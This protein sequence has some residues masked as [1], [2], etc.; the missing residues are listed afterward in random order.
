M[1]Q[2]SAAAEGRERERE[3][4]KLEAEAAGG[5]KDHSLREG[6]VNLAANCRAA[7]CQANHPHWGGAGECRGVNRSAGPLPACT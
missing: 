3:R 2:Q 4:M 5:K 1:I 7:E 6:G